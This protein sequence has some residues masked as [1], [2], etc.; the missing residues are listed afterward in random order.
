[1]KIN[2]CDWWRPFGTLLST[3]E[4]PDW[5]TELLRMLDLSYWGCVAEESTAVSADISP[6]ELTEYVQLCKWLQAWWRSW[7]LTSLSTLPSEILSLKQKLAAS[8]FQGCHPFDR[9]MVNW[10]FGVL[11][12]LGPGIQTINPNHQT[13]AIHRSGVARN[14]H[15]LLWQERGGMVRASAIPVRRNGPERLAIH[16]GFLAWSWGLPWSSH[17]YEYY[18]SWTR[19]GNSRHITNIYQLP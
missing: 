9:P 4:F 15:A 11:L 1:M 8:T 19:L 16:F 5:M 2:T 18:N 3:Q 6:S 7:W 14:L 12:L 10:W 17:L 13:I